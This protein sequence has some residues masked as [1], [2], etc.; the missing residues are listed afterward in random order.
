MLRKSISIIIVAAIMAVGMTGCGAEVNVNTAVAQNEATAE[1][2]APSEDTVQDDGRIVDE[3][4]NIDADGELMDYFGKN[5]DEL[6]SDFPNLEIF[7]EEGIYD[8]NGAQYIDKEEEF[9]GVLSGP[10]FD[11]DSDNNIV[12]ITY[13]G[14]RF[15]LEGL[16]AAMTIDDAIKTVKENG[17]EFADVDFAHG[18]AQYV[19]NY[20]KGDMML[21]I[22]STDEGEFGKSEESDVT[23][24]VETVSVALYNPEEALAD[25]DY[26]GYYIDKATELNKA[27]KADSFALI[28]VDADGV[29]EL[30]AADSKGEMREEG[31]AFLFTAGNGEA[32]KLLSVNSGFDGAHIYVSEG[33]N[34]IIETGSMSGNE[35]YTGYSINDGKLEKSR[36]LQAL[37]DPE[38]D[39][40]TYMDGDNEITAK[41]YADDFAKTIS[42]FDPFTGIDY[43]G[44]SKVNVTLKDGY[45]D[46]ETLSTQKYMTLDELKD[47]LK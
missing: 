47:K 36:E 35:R 23:G 5:I 26:A 24:S 8:K 9:D 42:E 32:V 45:V 17:W 44:L 28:D 6:M 14:R 30:A 10:T 15:V 29:P 31:N 34:N 43:D 19:M 41:Q 25:G 11:V 40:Y 46:F 27:G 33:K 39:E 16:C 37:V 2:G 13:T 1:D 12:G 22:V 38:T 21:T 18:T 3:E 7:S 20:T 4:R